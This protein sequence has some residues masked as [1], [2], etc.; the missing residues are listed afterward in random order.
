[1][2]SVTTVIFFWALMFTP[3]G[4]ILGA[5][6]V[7]GGVPLYYR[8]KKIPPKRQRIR[9]FKKIGLTLLFAAI[10]VVVMCAISVYS[11]EKD[12]GDYLKSQA[13]WNSWRIPLV[14]PYELRMVN[15]ME[16]G[17]ICA[18]QSQEPVIRDVIRFT[19]HGELI[20]GETGISRSKNDKD[21]LGWFLFD[22]TTGRLTTFTSRRELNK[23]CSSAYFPQP[24]YMRS[25]CESWY[26]HWSMVKQ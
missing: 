26:Q 10:F 17:S 6:G 22:C 13:G 2:K 18:W 12:K 19:K 11:L 25:V 8:L 9:L 7:F 21:I 5:L 15:S 16:S 20:A 14:K 24:L 4:I 23:A 1:M 3:A